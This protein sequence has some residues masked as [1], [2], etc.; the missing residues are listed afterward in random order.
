[1][2]EDNRLS[3]TLEDYLES[4][5][6]LCDKKGFA[7]VKEISKMLNVEMP[8]VTS[9]LKRLKDRRLILYEKYGYIE[10]TPDGNSIAGN[11]YNR[12]VKI[13]EFFEKLLNMDS[14]VAEENAC[15]I[16]HSISEDTFNRILSFLNF[17]DEYPEINK[18]ILDSFKLFLEIES[19]TENKE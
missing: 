9:A 15:K 3:A 10:L 7:R 14:E 5:K 2:E 17:L 12:H 6:M 18:S 4:I 19:K 11:I 8:S 16:E 13:K 1:M